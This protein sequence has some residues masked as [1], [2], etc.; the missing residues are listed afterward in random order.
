MSKS[1]RK[2]NLLV[3]NRIRLNAGKIKAKELAGLLGMELAALY[4]QAVRM[5]VS[6]RVRKNK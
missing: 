4:S 6:L 5:K 1:G 2:Q 3:H